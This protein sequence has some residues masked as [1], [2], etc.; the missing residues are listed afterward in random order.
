MFCTVKR[1]IKGGAR[2]VRR[3]VGRHPPGTGSSFVGICTPN[4][5]KNKQIW[6]LDLGLLP[7]SYRSGTAKVPRRCHSGT[8]QLPLCYLVAVVVIVVV[9]VVVDVVGVVPIVE[10][11]V[12]VV[13]VLL[14]LLLL[15][16]LIIVLI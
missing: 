13:A 8:T 4:L 7:L 1:T 16:L 10:I 3:D 11:C 2:R 15:L 14:L 12:P 5:W 9:V 6:Q